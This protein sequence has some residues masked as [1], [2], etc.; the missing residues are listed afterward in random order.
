MCVCVCV[1]VCVCARARAHMW[2]YPWIIVYLPLRSVTEVETF[3]TECSQSSCMST[4]Q[5]RESSIHTVHVHIAH[6]H[7]YRMCSNFH[8]M[9]LSW[10]SWIGSHVRTFY[11]DENLGRALVQ[12]PRWPSKEQGVVEKHCS[13]FALPLKT[14][15]HK[16]T[17]VSQ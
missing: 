5:E 8:G 4:V 15:I 13:A 11:A 6:T 3:D 9:K 10:F 16:L 17:V 7:I 14:F 2:V 1:C 12:W